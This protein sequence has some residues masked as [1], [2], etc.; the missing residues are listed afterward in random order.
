MSVFQLSNEKVAGFEVRPWTFATQSFIKFL[1]DKELSETEQAI[2]M[3]YLQSQAPK[4]IREFMQ[5]GSLLDKIT[6][7]IDNFPLYSVAEIYKWCQRQTELINTS[8]IEVLPR[9]EPDPK[10]PP[11]L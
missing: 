11:N 1:S 8:Q 6:D 4:S 3:V 5:D 2:A 9:G 7:F 10:T